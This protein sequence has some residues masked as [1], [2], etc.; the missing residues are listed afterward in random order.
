MKI[1]NSIKLDNIN[2]CQFMDIKKQINSN[3][4]LVQKEGCLKSNCKNYS[5]CNY[6][7]SRY[8]KR[9][10]ELYL[11]ELKG[12]LN[13]IKPIDKK[14]SSWKNNPFEYITIGLKENL[15]EKQEKLLRGQITSKILK[16]ILDNNLNTQDAQELYDSVKKHSIIKPFEIEVKYITNEKGVEERIKQKLKELDGKVTIIKI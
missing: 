3:N 11:N 14:E 8:N 7:I 12:S 9:E 6:Y 13:R 2:K 10:R 5:I 16:Y 4:I 1:K 15:Q